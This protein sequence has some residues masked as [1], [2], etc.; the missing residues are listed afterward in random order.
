MAIVTLSELKQRKI[1]KT[2]EVPV[3]DLGT[4]L[5][6]L[7]TDDEVIEYCKNIDDQT[8]KQRAS[9]VVRTTCI[10]EDQTQMFANGDK[11]EEL[12]QPLAHLMTLSAESLRLNG[13][14]NEKKSSIESNPS[15]SE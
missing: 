5:V 10:N 3:G 11:P 13:L 14:A 6:R 7:M 12:I 8:P 4:F 15:E 2:R 1:E 9:W